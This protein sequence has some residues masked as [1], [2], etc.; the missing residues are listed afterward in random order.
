MKTNIKHRRLRLCPLRG[1]LCGPTAAAHTLTSVGPSADY[2]MAVPR[3][4]D[5]GAG[6]SPLGSDGRGA[7]R[8]GGK[9]AVSTI[10]RKFKIVP[11]DSNDDSASRAKVCDSAAPSWLH[12]GQGGA[13]RVLGCGLFSAGAPTSPQAPEEACRQGLD[14]W[15]VLHSRGPPGT[16][17]Q[18]QLCP[19]G[20]G[21]AGGGFSRPRGPKE[22]APGPLL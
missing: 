20:H 6:L 22:E 10:F 13:A 1:N 19:S 21:P 11:P 8:G 7:T 9:G 3:R 2:P 17:G 18:S 14:T 15:K 12:P 16:E 5:P 4:A